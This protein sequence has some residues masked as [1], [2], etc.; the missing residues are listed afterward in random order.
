MSDCREEEPR[1]RPP[2]PP[3]FGGERADVMARLFDGLEQ[4]A[5]DLFA[6]ATNAEIALTVSWFAGGWIAHHAYAL[7]MSRE[8]AQEMGE[9]LI[10]GVVASEM[11]ECAVGHA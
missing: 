8:A 4:F 9:A 1:E 11:T 5:A 7:G 10:G 3:G 6:G 2:V